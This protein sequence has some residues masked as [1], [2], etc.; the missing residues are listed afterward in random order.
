[1]NF[2]VDLTISKLLIHENIMKEKPF[3]SIDNIIIICIVSY[4]KKIIILYSYNS[5]YIVMT[6]P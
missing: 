2:L 6:Y 5:S 3:T 4:I 1:M